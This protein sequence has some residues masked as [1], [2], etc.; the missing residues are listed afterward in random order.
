V[1]S[2]SI[3]GYDLQRSKAGL[4]FCSAASP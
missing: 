1:L 4:K 2:Q 3:T